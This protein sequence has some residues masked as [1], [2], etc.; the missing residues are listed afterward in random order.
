MKTLDDYKAELKES[1]RYP[2]GY[3]RDWFVVKGV[4]DTR[5]EAAKLFNG[6][7]EACVYADKYIVYRALTMLANDVLNGDYHV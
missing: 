6:W 5:L 4:V 2:F 3:A 7:D 1:V